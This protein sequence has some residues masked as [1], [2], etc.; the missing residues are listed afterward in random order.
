MSETE[1]TTP[2]ESLALMVGKA[3]VLCAAAWAG[4]VRLIDNVRIGPEHRR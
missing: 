4:G 1:P 2:D 3:A